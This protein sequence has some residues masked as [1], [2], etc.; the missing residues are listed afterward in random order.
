LIYCIRTGN[1]KRNFEKKEHDLHGR[2]PHWKMALEDSR[3]KLEIALMI[4]TCLLCNSFKSTI[5]ELKTIWTILKRR[6]RTSMGDDLNNLKSAE[7]N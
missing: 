7:N 2:C 4:K 5:V 1:N 6:K 3:N